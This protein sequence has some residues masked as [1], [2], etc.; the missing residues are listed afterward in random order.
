MGTDMMRHLAIAG[1]IAV[2]MAASVAPVQGQPAPTA[3]SSL[4][5]VT[6]PRPVLANGQ[7][8]PAGTYQVRLSGDA[9]TPAI[10]QSPEGAQYVEFLRAGQ[11]VGREVA[12]VLSAADVD[13]VAKGRRVPPG[14]ARVDLLR[15][16]DYLRVWINRG[17]T[18]FIIH[19]PPA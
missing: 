19:M 14:S 7:A 16:A 13:Q 2:L 5:N 18:H 3:G 6:L 4:G 17:G 8:I 11:V 15:G 1:A 12:T 10:G 9:P